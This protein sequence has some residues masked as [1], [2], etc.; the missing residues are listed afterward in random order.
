MPSMKLERYLKATYGVTRLGNVTWSHAVNSVEKLGR[1]VDNPATMFIESD[2]RLSPTQKLTA[3][4][5]H[6]PE[7]VSNLTFE[8]LIGTMRHSRKGLKLDFKDPEI[9]ERCLKMLQ[10]DPLNQP[11][12][13]NADILRGPGA[14]ISKFSAAGFLAYCA[15]YYPQG[16]LS[17][18]WTTTADPKNSYTK[19][20]VDEML[21]LC[22]HLDEV[23]FPVRAC[24][25]PNSWPELQRLLVAKPGY[26]LTIWNNEPVDNQLRDWIRANT[27]PAKTFYDFIDEQKE[28]MKLW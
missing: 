12:L 22:G 1:F 13:L 14:N 9:L 10:A 2:I 21:A 4:A 15:E 28:P 3:V 18:G 20:N 7:T 5:V 23:T 17:I 11:V 24:L 25:L 16:I 27:N 19:E 8:Q 6:P 26:T